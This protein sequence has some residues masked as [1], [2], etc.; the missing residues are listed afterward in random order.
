MAK[1]RTGLQSDISSIFSGVPIPKKGRSGSEPPDQKKPDSPNL[2]KP[3]VPQPKTGRP[4]APAQPGPAPPVTQQPAQPIPVV[5]P[6]QVPP[7]A[8]PER[9]GRKVPKK[10]PR[11]RK[12][13]AFAP[14]AGAS[15][16]RQ[17]MS[18]ALVVILSVVLVVVLARPFGATRRGPVAPGNNGP[19]TAGVLAVANV[20]ID[21]PEPGVYPANLRDPMISGSQGEIRTQTPDVLVVTAITYSE[22]VKLAV[23]GTEMLREGD[24]VQ[25]A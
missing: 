8:V 6:A 19:V 10:L 23:V 21:W 25:G 18:V 2:P 5:P 20:K 11:R 16:A 24:T 7:A 4:K 15:S 12:E 3:P 17:K 22:D 13:R 14:R 1:K 9:K